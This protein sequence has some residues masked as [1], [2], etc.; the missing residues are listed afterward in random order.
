MND[1]V[2]K[3]NRTANAPPSTDNFGD[4]GLS[5]SR[6]AVTNSA[7]PSKPLKVLI[8]YYSQEFGVNILYDDQVATQ[9]ITIQAP[10]RTITARP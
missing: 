1:K 6:T 8:D 9:R 2:P 5:A 3:K 4:Q 10:K 7:V